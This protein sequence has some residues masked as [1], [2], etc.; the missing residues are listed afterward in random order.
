V[1][2]PLHRRRIHDPHGR[3]AQLQTVQVQLHRQRLNDY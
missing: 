2:Q 1:G 3:K